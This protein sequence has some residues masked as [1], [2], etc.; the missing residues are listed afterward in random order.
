MRVLVG[1]ERSGVIRREF[2]QRGHDAWSC[3]LA[4]ADDNDPH[5]LQCDVLTIL[6]DRWDLAI[7]HPDCTYLANSSVQWLWRQPKKPKPGVLYGPPRWKALDEACAFFRR[8]LDAP[9]PRLACENPIPHRYAVERL[10]RSY[11]QLIQPY[12][13]GHPEMK[14]TCLW[15]KGLPPLQPTQIVELPD[16]QSEAQRIFH[17]RPSEE[18]SRLRSISYQGIGAAMADQWGSL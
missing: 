11:D 15:L 17:M 7:F 18:R 10:G 1:C 4:P 2:R 8:L 6:D 5:H 14:A 3:D 12:Q 13:F 9:I 16:K